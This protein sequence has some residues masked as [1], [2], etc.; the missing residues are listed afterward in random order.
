MMRPAR[1]FTLIE[2]LVVVAIIALVS[3]TVLA[4]MRDARLKAADAAVMRSA[5]ELRSIM[6]LER[7]NS[8]TYAAIKSGGQ[9]TGGGSFIRSR[10]GC[11]TF[12]GQFA[13]RAL[14]ICRKLVEAASTGSTNTTSVAGATGCGQGCVRFSYTNVVGSTPTNPP[15]RYSIQA[16]L[17]SKSLRAGAAR[18]LC[19]GSSGAVTTDS[20]GSAWTEPGCSDNP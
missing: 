17:P 9:G 15:D 10:E 5:T 16:Y 14:E 19:I 20:D 18:Y 2:M 4:A 3:S 8:G 11:G 6:E 13:T 12:S 1:G 7:T